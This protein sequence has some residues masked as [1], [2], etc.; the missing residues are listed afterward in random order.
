LCQFS[1]KIG[2]NID[3]IFSKRTNRKFSSTRPWKRPKKANGQF[4]NGTA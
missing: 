2:Y 1:F 3:N 4:K